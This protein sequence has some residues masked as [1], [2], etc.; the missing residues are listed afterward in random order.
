MIDQLRQYKEM[1]RGWLGVRIQQVTDDIAESLGIKQARGALI[2]GIDDKGPAKPAGIEP[3]D[4]IVKFDGKD[5]KEMR[6]LPRIVADTPVGKDVEVVII[7]KGKEEKKTVK[8]GRLEDGEKPRPA[9][10]KPSTPQDK[11]K[12]VVKKALGL[13]LANISD[14]LRKRYKIKESVK[15]SCHHRRRS[16]FGGRRQAA[17]GRRRDRRGRAGSGRQYRRLAEEGRQAEE[18]RPQ[19]RASSGR[20]CR[21]RIALRGAELAVTGSRCAPSVRPSS[22]AKAGDA[23]LCRSEAMAVYV[24]DALWRWQGLR[25]CHLLADDIDELHRFARAARLA[26]QL[27]SGPAKT[28]KP[29]YDLTAFERDRALRLGAVLCS[30]EE[31]VAVLHRVRPTADARSGRSSLNSAD[32]LV[33]LVS[34][35]VKQRGEIAM[36]D[37][38][39]R[40]RRD[41]GL[42]VIGDA[43]ARRLDHGEI[44][45]AVADAPSCL[46]GR[47]RA[48]R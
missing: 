33:P 1:R 7:R 39:M 17:V 48:A 22:P 3:G 34:L 30:R 9:S 29:H 24:D 44:V 19:V 43:E 36:V 10:V 12:T 32:E 47:C 31:I 15:G 38:R 4:V 6:D 40:G 23:R 46:P 35:H 45:G 20:Q 16:G 27:L 26:P 5:I 18:G 13:D 25:W 8:L 14:D 37:A 11:D 21:R 42:G 41:R 2:A 28:G